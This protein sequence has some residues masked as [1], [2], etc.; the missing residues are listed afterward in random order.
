MD[1]WTVDFET[2]YGDDFTLSKMTT[3]S[4]VRDP[5]FEIILCSFK[6]NNEK[7]YWVDSPDVVKHLRELKLHRSAVLAQ[8]AH[9]DGLILS[10]HA[11]VRPKLWLD[12]LSMARA[13]HGGKGGLSL[14]KLAERYGLQAKGGE[15]H[16]ARGLR[17]CDFSPQFLK[18]Y[19]HYSCNDSDLEYALF[20][21][22]S[23]HF[24]K[25]ELQ[26]IDRHIRMFTEPCMVAN[27]PMLKQYL[28]DVQVDKNLALLR[29]GLQKT[30]VMSSAKFAS[31][32]ENLGVEPPM[33]VSPRTGKLTY[34]FAKSDQAM[35]ELA[36]HVDED[37]QAVVA[38]RLKNKSTINE[39]R[40]VRIL[41]MA[42]RGPLCIYVKYYGADQTGRGSGGDKMNWQNLTRG[43]ILRRAIGGDSGKVVVVGDSSNIEA[44]LNDWIWGQKNMVAAYRR[45]DRGEGPDIYCIMAELIYGYPVT[46]EE[47][48]AERQMG[49]VAKLGLGY[50]MGDKKFPFAVRAQAKDKNDKPLVITQDFSTF[51]VRTYR[52]KHEAV[53]EGWGLCENALWKILRGIEGVEVDPRGIITTCKDGLLL[54]NGLVIRYPKM[55]YAENQETGKMEFTYWNGRSREK[56]YGAKVCENIVQALARIVV[57]YQCLMV[58]RRRN[59]AMT[60]HDEGAW[61]VPREDAEE[62][63]KEVVTAFRTPLAWCTTLPLNCEV[64]FHRSYGRAKT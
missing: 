11:G 17:R 61:I 47:F 39:S 16:L 54:P 14:G 41:S 3:E 24:C 6:L 52:T 29:A 5:R 64:K 63:A 35:Q 32:L 34:A 38:A 4:Y 44:R 55:K 2:Y 30:D 59:W 27:V 21:L 56:I 15:V 51:V 25:E 19:G 62:V 13:L 42:E 36:E 37:V 20:E 23:P 60:V 53:V 7:A 31:A 49:K 18:Q 50:G 48:P 46:K 28:E 43:S 58:P 22:M 40:A 26:L 57:M 8:H 10:H 45:Y 9:F 1:V 12:T 33:K